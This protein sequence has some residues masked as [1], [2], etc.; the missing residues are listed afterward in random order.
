MTIVNHHSDGKS[1]QQ[2]CQRATRDTNWNKLNENENENC[3][4]ETQEI[5]AKGEAKE[6]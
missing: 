3:K 2:S 5:T 4:N 6:Q 1:I